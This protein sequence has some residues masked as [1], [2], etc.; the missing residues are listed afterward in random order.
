MGGSLTRTPQYCL[1]CTS[2]TALPT[3]P[4]T[5]N[6]STTSTSSSGTSSGDDESIDIQVMDPTFAAASVHALPSML[7][8]IP[9][10]P[11]GQH[12]PSTAGMSSIASL[13]D[14]GSMEFQGGHVAAFADGAC[15]VRVGETVV[16]ATATSFKTHKV[17]DAAHRYTVRVGW[18]AHVRMWGWHGM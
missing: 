18:Y 1:A 11:I 8:H 15:V 7:D 5:N 6:D 14:G 17:Y 16:L 4:E 9:A 3:P 12:D 2:T 13:P 10:D